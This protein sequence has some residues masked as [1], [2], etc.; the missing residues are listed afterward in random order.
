MITYLDSS[1]WIKRYFDE[2]VSDV[3]T[4]LMND[5]EVIA[6][7]SIGMIEVAATIARKGR[8]ERL[9]AV[10]LAGLL[11][12]ARSDLAALEVIPLDEAVARQ[13]EIAAF[14]HGLRAGDAVHLASALSLRDRD[15]VTI[16]SSDA[17]VACGR[18]R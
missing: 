12:Q 17:E 18:I 14:Q 2:V 13:A 16:V 9:D 7:S 15:S 1:A 3:V 4:S 5:A 8:H 10:I 6:C 11:A